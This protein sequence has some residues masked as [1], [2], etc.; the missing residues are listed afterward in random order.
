MSCDIELEIGAGSARGQF[1]TR[2][3]KAPSGGEP[4]ASFELDFD[5]LLRERDALENTVLA[6]GALG[7]RIVPAHEQQLRRIGRRLFDALFSG[8]V[9]DSYRASLGVAQQRN[10]PLP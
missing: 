8:H 6:S 7:R 2:V 1:I 5:D 10:E 9:I 3:V 4:S